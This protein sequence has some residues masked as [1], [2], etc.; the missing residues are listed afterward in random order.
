MAVA[1]SVEQN[2]VVF[3]STAEP[4]PRSRSLTPVPAHG[5][6]VSPVKRLAHSRQQAGGPDPAPNPIFSR[7]TENPHICVSSLISKNW[8][9]VPF[10][11]SPAPCHDPE[12]HAGPVGV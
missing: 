10:L 1:S 8:K 9:P 5:Y 11:P 7:E 6:N 3:L 2:D 12:G 4:S